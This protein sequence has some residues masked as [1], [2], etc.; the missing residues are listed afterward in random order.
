MEPLATLCSL[1]L[2]VVMT[3]N[4][5][6]VCTY[7]LERTAIRYQHLIPLVPV[8]LS[9]LVLVGYAA[10]PSHLAWPLTMIGYTMA[11]LGLIV[12]FGMV[13]RQACHGRDATDMRAPG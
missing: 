1:L 5:S 10:T 11:Y 9:F 3:A 6:V 8:G 2:F 13:Q 4:A 7:L 12:W